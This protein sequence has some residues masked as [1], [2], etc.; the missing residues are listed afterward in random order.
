MDL[1]EEPTSQPASCLLGDPQ[2]EDRVGG[3]RPASNTYLTALGEVE[4]AAV[5]ER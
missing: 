5:G 1:K 4:V 3:G 2:R